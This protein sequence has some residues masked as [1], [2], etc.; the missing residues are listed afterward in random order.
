MR[1]IIHSYEL[2][3]SHEFNLSS[4]LQ[5]CLF[6]GGACEVRRKTFFCMFRMVF[7][8]S[9]VSFTFLEF[10]AYV[11]GEFKEPV[12]QPSEGRRSWTRLRGPREGTLASRVSSHSF[13][14]FKPDS[15]DTA[16]SGFGSSNRLRSSRIC[17]GPG[18][19]AG[20]VCPHG[21][22]NCVGGGNSC[23]EIGNIKCRHDLSRSAHQ[24]K[25][26]QKPD[27]LTSAAL[28]VL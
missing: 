10:R 12:T 9:L 28:A 27:K 24:P 25:F 20:H 5:Y 23:S 26:L 4:S 13:V 16:I 18:I 3:R 6:I 11:K 21:W 15:D 1:F 14:W 17:C 19:F 8:A 7:P 2:R 22:I